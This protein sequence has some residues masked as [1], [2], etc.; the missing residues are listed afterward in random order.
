M[1]GRDAQSSAAL[2]R[3]VSLIEV[4]LFIVIISAALSGIIGTLA[5]ASP[6]ASEPLIQRQ[7][8]AIAESLLQEILAQPFTVNDPDG[9]VDAIG[10]EAGEARGSSTLPF[11]HVNDYHGYSTAGVIDANGAA[12]AG[13]SAY[14]VAVT[15]QSQALDVVGA[16]DGLLVRVTVTGPGGVTVSLSGFRARTS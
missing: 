11:D 15:V 5:W 12:V 14:S 1:F 13:L 8:L 7:A 16:S 6:R 3:G 2:Q 4:V 9:G 10:P